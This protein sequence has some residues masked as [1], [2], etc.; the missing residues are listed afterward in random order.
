MIY[1]PLIKKA[2]RIAARAHAGQYDKAGYPYIHHP[3][4]LA[5]SMTDEESTCAALLHDVIEDTSV[6]CD[7]LRAE[8]I[9]EGVLTALMLLTHDER[10]PYLD[11]VAAI[12]DNSIAHAVKLADLA[13]NSDLSRLDVM[14]EKA[15]ARVDRYRKATKRL[16]SEV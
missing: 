6:T 5:E 13:H 3:L 1:T 16:L 4:H 11:Y 8:G 10:V 9:P 7:E 2:M 15:L 14:D 12:K